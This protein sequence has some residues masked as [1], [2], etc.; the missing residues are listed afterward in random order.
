MQYQESLQRILNVCVNDPLL[1]QLE[2]GQ[3]SRI[4]AAKMEPAA[5]RRIEQEIVEQQDRAELQHTLDQVEQ[6]HRALSAVA[7]LT[8]EQ[9]IQLGVLSGLLLTLS[10]E[11]LRRASA[12]GALA[13]YT[14]QSVLPW[15]MRAASCGI[16][17]GVPGVVTNLIRSVTCVGAG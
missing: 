17:G 13:A 14:V 4:I 11:A 5:L 12:A 1:G 16:L 6:A 7:E 10:A 15:L 2:L 9:L 3:S 8:P